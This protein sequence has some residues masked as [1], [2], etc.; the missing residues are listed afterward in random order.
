MRLIP[1]PLFHILNFV[2]HSEDSL[3]WFI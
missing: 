1:I 3:I 2:A